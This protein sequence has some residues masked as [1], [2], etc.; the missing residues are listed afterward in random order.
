MNTKQR[1]KGQGL[2]EY[3]LIFAL[4]VL[5]VVVLLWLFGD[6]LGQIYSSIIETI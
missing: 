1:E 6:Q 3:A 5:V 4:V 2:V